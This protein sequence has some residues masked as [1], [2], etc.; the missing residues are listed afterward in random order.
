MSASTRL[1]AAGAAL[2]L[3][4]G[5]GPGVTAPPQGTAERGVRRTLMRLNDRLSRRDL[6]LVDDFAEGPDT[7]LVG[8]E[9]GEVA[10]GRD[11]VEAHF[12]A[13]FDRPETVAFSWRE[14]EVAVHGHVAFL[15]AEGEVVVSGGEGGEE[16][17]PYRLTGVL[18]LRDGLWR[19]RLYHGSEPHG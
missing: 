15:H 3:V 11:G 8:S 6:S 16:R 9:V 7:L 1:L 19:W 17:R 18:Q 4:L 10:R 14:V 5:L 13:L 12:K 2:L